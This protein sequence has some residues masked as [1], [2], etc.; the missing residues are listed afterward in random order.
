MQPRFNNLPL[1]LD[2]NIDFDEG[3]ANDEQLTKKPNAS[4]SERFPLSVRRAVPRALCL[5]LDRSCMRVPAQ[6]ASRL[7]AKYTMG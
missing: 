6:W 4:A 7:D 5:D 2:V 1:H 3:C